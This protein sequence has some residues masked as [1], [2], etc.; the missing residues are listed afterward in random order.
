M[1]QLQHCTLG[2]RPGLGGPGSR[3]LGA[4][5]GATWLT[6]SLTVPCCGPQR[7]G[8]AQGFYQRWGEA[9]PGRQRGEGWLPLVGDT[10]Q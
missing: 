4:D 2:S 9:V 10:C 6:S 7:P 8:G 3:G 5:P 1:R